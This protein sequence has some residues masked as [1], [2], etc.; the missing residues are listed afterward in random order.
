MELNVI[1]MKKLLFFLLLSINIF[2]QTIFDSFELPNEYKRIYNDNY[3]KWLINQ[4]IILDEEVKTY[5]GEIIKGLGY[6][7]IAKFNYNIGNKNLHQCADAIIYLNAMFNYQIGD[8][9]KIK[10]SSNSGKVMAFTSFQYASKKND[11]KSYLEYVWTWAGTWS[12][13]KY[14]TYKIDI[15][16]IRPGDIFIQGGSPGHAIIVVDVVENK[17]NIKKVMLAQSYMPAQ[18]THILLNN[19]YNVWHNLK[20]DIENLGFTRFNLKRFKHK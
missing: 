20:E 10:Y 16:T 8:W 6:S 14:D 15:K 7:Y 4:P 1:K 12:L 13:E 17:K 19:N 3:S 9:Y 11:F 5:N 2:S 18:E